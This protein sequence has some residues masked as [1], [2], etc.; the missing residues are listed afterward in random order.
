MVERPQTILVR[1]PR[2]RQALARCL[3]VRVLRRIVQELRQ[4]LLPSLHRR[5]REL[6]RRGFFLAS[7]IR[8]NLSMWRGRGG[9]A[10]SADRPSAQRGLLRG[11]GFAPEAAP[12]N[13]VLR[14]PRTLAKFQVTPPRVLREIRRRHPS[15][16]PRGG[17]PPKSCNCKTCPGK[18]CECNLQTLHLQWLQVAFAR[19]A[20][21]NLANASRPLGA[22]GG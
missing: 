2:L 11:W 14:E 6:A 10:L 4:P 21:A 15:R 8:R 19:F 9:G 1:P 7:P 13:R 12:H 5:R 16:L 22:M 18:S 20:R 3:I 17:R